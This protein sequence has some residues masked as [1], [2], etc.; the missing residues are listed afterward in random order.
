MKLRYLVSA[1]I[2]AGSIST[3]IGQSQFFQIC[4]PVPAYTNGTHLIPILAPDFAPVASITDGT[5][6]F[7]LSAGFTA[8]TVPAGG[9][10][11]WNSPPF[12]ESA[13]P[14]VLADFGVPTTGTITLLVPSNTVGFEIEPNNFG[15]FPVT[16]TFFNGATVLGTVNLTITGNAGALLSAGS[17]TALITSVVITLPAAAGGFGIAEPRYGPFIPAASGS[18]GAQ[19]RYAANLSAG[20]SYVDIAYDG[21]WGA[22][23]TGPGFGTGNVNMCANLY[24]IDPGEELV[25][26]CQC[27]ITPD[28]DVGLD[29]VQQLTNGSKG[30]INGSLPN[31]VTIRIMG[32]SGNCATNNAATAYTPAPGLEA[33]GTTLHPTPTSGVY[34]TTETPFSIVTLGSSELISLQGRC[35]EIIG[36]DSTYG[37]CKGCP[38]TNAGALGATKQ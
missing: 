2:F 22:S 28:Q 16:A 19:V 15:T 18:C 31:S 12:T 4:L 37:Q 34:A 29:V 32:S 38:T 17:D 10:A 26:C 3:A 24:F 21:L 25:S 9:W 6:T 1:V 27:Q 30:T 35:A 23:P 8:Q 11:T 5:Q 36:N 33:W 20:T 13:T 14:R 7:T